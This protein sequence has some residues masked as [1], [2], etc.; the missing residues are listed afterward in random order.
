M[1]WPCSTG[2]H[3]VFNGEAVSSEQQEWRAKLKIKFIR[4][5]M[6]TIQKRSEASK[7]KQAKSKRS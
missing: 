3:E 2:R 6:S 5:Y 7:R 1:V 4:D